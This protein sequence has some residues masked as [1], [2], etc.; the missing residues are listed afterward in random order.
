MRLTVSDSDPPMLTAC[1]RLVCSA[2][3]LQ[4][5]Q[6]GFARRRSCSAGGL[7]EGE[8]WSQEAAAMH[9]PSAAGL[10]QLAS[11]PREFVSERAP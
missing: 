6:L 2:W 10:R 3:T 7:P 4:Y 11:A 8:G 9:G 1:P 5:A